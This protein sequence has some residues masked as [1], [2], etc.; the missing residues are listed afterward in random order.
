MGAAG[1]ESQSTGNRNLGA[2]TATYTAHGHLHLYATKQHASCTGSTNTSNQKL[3]CYLHG[4]A[5]TTWPQRLCNHD[6]AFQ[7]CLRDFAFTALSLRICLDD[8]AS[9][10][11]PPRPAKQKEVYRIIGCFVLKT[12]Q[13]VWA[14][15][16]GPTTPFSPAQQPGIASS[17]PTEILTA[18]LRT[19]TLTCAMCEPQA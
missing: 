18:C 7:P 19:P 15:P 13:T 3:H 16:P 2:H 17:L 11:L 14:Q 4:G 12:L 10:T 8:F 6:F 9:A 5:Y 1:S